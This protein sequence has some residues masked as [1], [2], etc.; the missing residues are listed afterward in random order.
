MFGML[1][2]REVSFPASQK[3]RVASLKG[4]RTRGLILFDCNERRPHIQITYGKQQSFVGTGLIPGA[5][6]GRSG[7]SSHTDSINFLL[8]LLK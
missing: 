2:L 8:V 3:F 6:R 1:P 5:I 4:T 7:Y